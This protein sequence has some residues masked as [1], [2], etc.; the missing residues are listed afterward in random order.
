MENWT[1]IEYIMLGVIIV[2]GILSIVK[3]A[4]AI[5]NKGGFSGS[6]V[7]QTPKKRK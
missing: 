5:K 7:D 1:N 3:A 2:A 4:K 6:G